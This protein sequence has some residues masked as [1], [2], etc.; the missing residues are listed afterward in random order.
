MRTFIL[1]SFI[2]IFFLALGNLFATLRG[3]GIRELKPDSNYICFLNVSN[4]GGG[5]SCFATPSCPADQKL[6]VRV[7]SDAEQV[8]IGFGGYTG[9]LTFRITNLDHS[10]VFGPYTITATSSEGY[11]KYYSQADAGPMK[12]SPS[13]YKALVFKPTLPG[14]YNIEI[15]PKP[16]TLFDITV[17][18]TTIQPFTAINGRLWSKDWGFNTSNIDLPGAAFLATQYIYTEDSIVTSIYYNEMRGNVFDVTSTRNGCYPPPVPW[19]SSCKSTEGNHHYAQYK[20]FVNDPDTLEFPTG[21]LGIIL[22]SSVTVTRDCDGS[23]D[24]QFSVNKPGSANV[25]LEINPLPGHQPEDVSILD[26]VDIG[27]NTIT[28]NGI[29]G[30]GVPVPIGDSVYISIS[31]VNG[32]TNLALYDVERHL[33]GF[34]IS[35]VRP[36]GPPIATYWND[37]LLTH[38]GGQVQLS[39]CYPSPPTEGC[40]AW[41]GDYYGV[42]I[43]SWNTVNTWWYVASN[44][45]VGMYAVAGV[46]ETPLG[47][48]GPDTLCMSTIA[49]YT[50][51]PNPLPGADSTGYEWVL[52]DVSSGFVLMDSLN[53]LS[54]ITIDYSQFPP[55]QKRLKVRGHSNYC[56]IGAYGPG[57]NGIL[58]GINMSPVITNSNLTDT[59]CTGTS[60]NI[61]LQA[62]NPLTTFSYTASATSPNISGY[63]SGTLNPI[64]QMLTNSG[65]EVDSVVYKVV[66]F[67]S[68][69][70]GDTAIFY[71]QVPPATQVTNTDTV[72][73]ICS[74]DSVIIPLTSN[75]AG[76]SF[77]WTTSC[78]S[79][80]VT[81][82]SNGDGDT[83]CQPLINT[84]PI[85][86]TVTYAVTPGIDGCPG[87]DKSFSV[88]VSPTPDLS[89]SPLLQ[90]LCSGDSLL[91]TLTSQV[92]GALFTW[93]AEASSPD[94]SGYSSNTTDPDTLISQLLV[95]NS[96]TAHAVAYHITPA[97]NGC[98]GPL[99]DYTVNVIPSITLTTTPLATA[100]CSGD[101]VKVFLSSSP[102]GGMFSWTCTASSPNLSG[103]TAQPTPTDSLTQTVTNSGTTAETVTYTLSSE[104]NGCEGPDTTFVITVSPILPVDVTVSVSTNPV[105]GGIPVTFTASPVNEGSS[106]LYHWQVNGV[107][108]G[109]NNPVYTYYPIS[110]D[111][112]TCTLTSSEPCTSNNPASGNLITMS[113][114]EA[115]E[116]SFT[117]CFDTITSIS[118]QPFRLKG[119][120]PL[121]GTYSGSGVSSESGGSGV[122]YNFDPSIAGAGS[123]QITYSYTNSALCE[124]TSALSIFNYQLSIFNCG[125]NLLDIR[126]SSSYP[127]VLIGLQCWMATNLNY[128]TEIPYTSPQRDNCIP[129]KYCNTVFPVPCALSS[130]LYQWDELMTYSD[131]EGSQGLCPPGWHVPSET[132]WNQLFALFLGN[133]FAG[134]PLL[135]SGYSGFNAELAGINAFSQSWHFDGFAAIFW[136]ST[137]HGPWKA[138]AHGMNDYNTSVSYYP[139][140][141]ANAFSVRCLID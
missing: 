62:T 5:Y 51:V 109:T 132:D 74:G 2:F 68:P 49:T 20:I 54:S 32:L 113:I 124:A 126:D 73:G 101:T 16:M 98:E 80:T 35:M 17:I 141:R 56:G 118:A 134:S 91:L 24:I 123:H 58:V 55:G 76:C 41:Q 19:D 57:G 21:V 99:Y 133:A 122:L 120:I 26:S 50:V 78:T 53:A 61:L 84:G 52:T 137:A 89:N 102:P 28:W 71:I 117:A 43:G 108:A 9:N 135:N 139:G 131:D 96:T 86:E 94:L 100:S 47:I 14:D 8:Y 104:P 42:G 92:T 18:D 136:S 38:K 128:G 31:Y 114:G 81:G 116:V 64:Q 121:G 90:E 127:T 107:D 111:Q 30:L 63:M 106:P 129:E 125:D 12:I 70:T 39:G 10:V 138:W 44:S 85:P 67:A 48:S 140:Y 27:V 60:T 115:P 59:V 22:P 11:I 130:V 69:C 15:D 37:T 110:G 65:T 72:F 103:Y 105:C 119:G 75:L 4:G 1:K 29:N 25:E 6:Y 33:N 23:F 83:I 77:T 13:G 3:E 97:A 112:V 88:T 36:L 46:P 87:P 45:Q 95:N 34:I 82:F 40:H 66:P 79:G 93:T 7:G